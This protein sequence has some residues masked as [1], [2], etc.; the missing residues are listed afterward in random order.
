MSY[1]LAIDQGSHASRALLFDD[2][3]NVLSSCSRDID[4]NR[5]DRGRVEH[6]AEQLLSSVRDVI[7][8]LFS[9]LSAQE[10]Q[11]IA[12]CGIATQRSTVLAWN[13]DGKPVGP[14]LSWQDVRAAK[15]LEALRDRE[16]QIQS[17]T[18]LPL[19]A[20]YG[21]SKLNWLLNKMSPTNKIKPGDTRLSPL[22]SFLLYHL[23]ENKPYCVDHSNAQRT[24]LMDVVTLDWSQ[25]LLQWFG[26]PVDYLP[27]CKPMCAEYGVLSGS[28][29]NV[30]AVCGDQN[31]ALFGAGEITEDTALINLGS[32][33][34][35]LR[36]LQEHVSSHKQLTGIACSDGNTVSYL[37][38][39]TINGAGSALNWVAEK[40]DIDDTEER[41]SDWIETI[42]DPPLFINTI[43]GLGSPWWRQDIEPE[44][45]DHDDLNN[46]GALI[47]AVIES[48]VFMLCANLDLMIK[49][50]PL[51]R[52][53]V[54]GGLSN[55]DGLCQ[56]LANLCDLPVERAE[57]PEAT[58]RGVA[59]LA[60]G[61]PAHWNSP[62]ELPVT[63][64][65]FRPIADKALEQRYSQYITTLD[66]KLREKR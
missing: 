55:V 64:D 62:G 58:A 2:R 3:G 27:E 66:K 10:R 39:A 35:I 1:Y 25:Q 31:A 50:S 11:N 19:S 6:D 61:R 13:I 4:V 32:G 59:W 28:R 23:V 63:T 45:I 20:H 44:F 29:V 30:T 54:S 7:A 52:L 36:P 22:V 18:G 53:R 5:F 26:V 47:V 9:G 56:K 34:F 15:L 57:N 65:I 51:R 49:E 60:A 33:A 48:I 42:E 38:E 24:Q 12:A 14:V 43:G 16:Q 40:Y 46:K 17:I 41:L 21:A 8:E 37:R